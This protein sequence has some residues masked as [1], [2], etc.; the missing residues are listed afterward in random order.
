MAHGKAQKDHGLV[1]QHLENLSR[2]VLAEYQHIIREY[3]RG[4]VG[5]YALYRR[6]KLYYVGLASN[7]RNRLKTHLKDKHAGSWDRFSVYLTTDDRHLRELES[8]VLRIVRPR[9][10]AQ[11]GR[12][13]SS[14]NLRAR[15]QRDVWNH[16]RQAT[17]EMFG[18]KPRVSRSSIRRGRRK[19]TDD[20]LPLAGVF[21]RPVR[22]RKRYKGCLYQARLRR[23]GQIRYAGK[24]Y[25]S[26][27]L[28]AQA[29][30]KRPTNGWTFW[31]VERSPGE[32]VPL[33]DLRT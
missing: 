27:S 18:R 26:P 20:R 17:R 11:V 24:L 31:E 21:S 9:G 32:W 16:L 5:M 2:A 10:N 28:A 23:D 15:L 33:C 6:G 3:V 14:E 4:R 12:F 13:A 7:L 19:Q 29:V 30:R 22:L 25:T 8:L 1:C